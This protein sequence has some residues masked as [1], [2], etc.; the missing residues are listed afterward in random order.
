MFCLMKAYLLS[1]VTVVPQIG[2]AGS[3]HVIGAAEAL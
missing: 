3:D 2:S 1:G